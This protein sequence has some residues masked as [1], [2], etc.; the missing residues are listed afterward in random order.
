MID[1]HKLDEFRDAA[2]EGKISGGRP[3]PHDICGAFIIPSPIDGEALR[4]M[5]SAG[6]ASGPPWDHVSVSRFERC[7][8]WEEMDFIARKFFRPH[9]AAMQLHVPAS[10]HVNHHPNC[11]HLWRPTGLKKIPLPPSIMVG[12]DSAKGLGR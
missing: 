10:E 1:L 4:C 8:W 3:F 7:P 5:V 2:W 6:F 12:P 9:E 11:L